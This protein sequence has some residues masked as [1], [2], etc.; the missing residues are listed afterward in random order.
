MIDCFITQRKYWQ[1]FISRSA[2]TVFKI[3]SLVRRF[4]ELGPVADRSGR[5]AHRN[6][7]TEYNVETVRYSVADDPFVSTRRH[8]SQ[9]D[10]PRTSPYK[11]AWNSTNASTICC[12]DEM[13]VVGSA[14]QKDRERNTAVKKTRGAYSG[15]SRN[16]SRVKRSVIFFDLL[17]VACRRLVKTNF[18]RR[19]RLTVVLRIV[20]IIAVKTGIFKQFQ[21]TSDERF[22]CLTFL[23]ILFLTFLLLY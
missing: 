14:E 23:I 5:G 8:S 21:K 4:V 12:N 18:V 19:C 20:E 11:I 10:I 9:L 1:H 7:S 3:R 17:L 16:E 22:F 6:I 13:L 15:D 2:P